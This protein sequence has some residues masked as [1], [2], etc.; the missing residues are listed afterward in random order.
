MG[1][2]CRESIWTPDSIWVESLGL[3]MA[4]SLLRAQRPDANDVFSLRIG[5]GVLR[6]FGG[7]PWRRAE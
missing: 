6:H 2:Y 4:L 1:I 5:Y 3:L 7:R